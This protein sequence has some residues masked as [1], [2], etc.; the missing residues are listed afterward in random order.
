MKHLSRRGV[1]LTVLLVGFLTVVANAD[2]ALAKNNTISQV[3]SVFDATD[4]H[5]VR[6]SQYQLD[7][8]MGNMVTSPWKMILATILN[9]AWVGYLMVIGVVGWAADTTFSM[10]WI[11]VITGPLDDANHHIHDGVLAPLGGTSLAMAGIMGLLFS[12]CALNGVLKLRR[13][14]LASAL[15]I[16]AAG[17]LAAALAVGALA[18][19]VATFVGTS[20]TVAAPLSAARDTAQSLASIAG[21]FT[22]STQNQKNDDKDNGKKDGKNDG[23]DQAAA[24]PISAMLIATLVRPAH[25]E[26]GYG[27]IIDGQKCSDGSDAAAAYDKALKDGPNLDPASSDQ[28]DAIGKCKKEW[29]DYANGLNFTWFAPTS[30]FG[31]AGIVVSILVGTVIVQIWLAVITM[32]ISS[33]MA[34]YHALLAIVSPSAWSSLARD[35]LEIALGVVAVVKKAVLLIMILLMV[36]TVLGATDLLGLPFP[37]RFLLADLLMV[38]GVVFFL[39]DW[40]R[41]HQLRDRILSKISSRLGGGT[42]HKMRDILTG[43]GGAELLREANHHR[44]QAQKRRSSARP[45]NNAQPSQ[46]GAV[47][48]PTATSTARTGARKAEIGRA[49]V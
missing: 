36:R 14:G 4:S 9:F 3:I 19:P 10:S 11:T 45:N 6:L 33:F 2:P 38:A 22:T 15:M 7:P 41:D 47:Q 12:I 1:I 26:T 28:R 34:A 16:W 13:G 25:Q 43:A 17:G 35:G 49:H 30:L 23:D 32:A 21:G 29:K 20:T 8:N 48:A 37:A 40:M 24:H 46:D 42:N 39:I 27:A 31:I 5:G 18:F 44:H